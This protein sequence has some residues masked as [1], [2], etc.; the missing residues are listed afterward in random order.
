MGRVFGTC[1]VTARTVTVM[2][3]MVAEAAQP[4]PEFIMLVSCA[5]AAILTRFL[6][7]PRELS[8]PDLGKVEQAIEMAA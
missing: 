6:R 1:N 5:V 4:T 7:R 3:S 2:S 8:K